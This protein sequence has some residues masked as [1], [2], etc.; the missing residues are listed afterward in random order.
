[1]FFAYHDFSHVNLVARLL[2]FSYTS[3]RHQIGA[4]IAPK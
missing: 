3:S 4:E 1:M 2:G